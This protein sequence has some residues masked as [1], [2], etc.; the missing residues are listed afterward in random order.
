MT[1]KL[2]THYIS[3]GQLIAPRLRC[4]ACHFSQGVLDFYT[5]IAHDPSKAGD[6][7][8]EI[9]RRER[10]FRPLN[11][12]I[13]FTELLLDLVVGNT[14]CIA[15]PAFASPWNHLSSRA[16]VSPV[17]LPSL[18]RANGHGAPLDL[19]P[20]SRLGFWVLGIFPSRPGVSRPL[21]RGFPARKAA[22]GTSA[23]HG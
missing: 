16:M 22:R 2:P 21:R 20:H 18:Q 6:T 7:H 15:H 9:F 19:P 3:S 11:F 4:K 5:I 23:K 17:L 10:E 14:P 1:C 12:T 13:A 8:I